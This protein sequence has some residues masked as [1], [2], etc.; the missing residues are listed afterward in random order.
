MEEKGKREKRKKK[1]RGKKNQSLLGL[2][3]Y[4][5]SSSIPRF[6]AKDQEEK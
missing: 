3:P 5:F 4:H 6:L 1:K 2:V